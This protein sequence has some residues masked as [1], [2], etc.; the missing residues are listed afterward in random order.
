MLVVNGFSN[1][2]A[3]DFVSMASQYVS[4]FTIFFNINI[5]KRSKKV[6][7]IILSSQQK[8]NQ[9]SKRTTNKQKGAQVEPWQ[10]PQEN[11]SP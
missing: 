10:G 4:L 8:E 11:L 7:G 6:Q 1:A 5:H 2:N 9:Q 3:F